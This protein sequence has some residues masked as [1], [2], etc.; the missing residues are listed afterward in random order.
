MPD[1]ESRVAKPIP[2]SGGVVEGPNAVDG[3]SLQDVPP[4]IYS[5]TQTCE[6]LS[7][8]LMGEMTTVI[9]AQPYPRPDQNLLDPQEQGGG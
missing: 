3:L 9:Q 4:T 8:E 5:A 7:R 1:S 6:Q 2:F